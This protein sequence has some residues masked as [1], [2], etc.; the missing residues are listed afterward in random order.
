MCCCAMRVHSDVSLFSA[1]VTYKKL[2]KA[3]LL[4]VDFILFFILKKE[5]NWQSNVHI[6][7]LCFSNVLLAPLR[8]MVL[9]VHYISSRLCC[10]AS[11][12]C[13]NLYS[14]SVMGKKRCG[15][16]HSALIL[17]AALLFTRLM[18]NKEVHCIQH[19]R[20]WDEWTIF[21]V[22]GQQL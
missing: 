19:G 18:E 10:K 1:V 6:Y 21:P 8:F 12:S 14:Q 17:I 13:E 22:I 9:Y 5:Q 3:S 2:F 11:F 4:E 20:G 7:L 16:E 15:G